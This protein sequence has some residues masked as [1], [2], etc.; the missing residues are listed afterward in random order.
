MSDNAARD[1]SPPYMVVTKEIG[2]YEVS[3]GFYPGFVSAITVG[4]AS[5]YDQKSDGPMPFNLPEGEGP[6]TSSA[7]SLSSSKGYRVVLSVDDPDQ[8]IDKLNLTL[9]RP[10]TEGGGVVAHQEGDDEWIINDRAVTC[11]PNC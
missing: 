1:P 4:G 10:L 7:L 5:L 9:R 8:V 11:P 2:G 3:A 6:W